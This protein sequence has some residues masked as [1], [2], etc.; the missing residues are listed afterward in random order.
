MAFKT[1]N[2]N[3]I[4]KCLAQSK[5]HE[6]NLNMVNSCHKTPLAYSSRQILKKLGLDAGVTYIDPKSVNAASM[7][8]N[9]SLL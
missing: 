6:P 5:F 9:N 3:L 2:L 4:L 7:F 8:N 1:N